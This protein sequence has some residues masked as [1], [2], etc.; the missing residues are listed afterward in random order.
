MAL[1]K[2]TLW[3]IP[4]YKNYTRFSNLID[5]IS[6]HHC[7][8]LM[9]IGVCGGYHARQMIL[10]ALEVPGQVKYYG[11]DLFEDLTEEI[12]DTEASPWPKTKAQ[13]EH[14]LKGIGVDVQLFKGFT[15]DTLP[16]FLKLNIRPD[17]IFI[18]GGHSYETVENDW[19]YVKQM[20]SDETI[21]LFDD[22]M[23]AKD[24]LGW[25]CHKIIDDLDRNLYSVEI[26]E[27]CDVYYM[28]KVGS[29]ERVLTENRIA[30]VWMNTANNTQN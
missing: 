10:T 21:V 11:F 2:S 25:G 8:V 29:D 15:R 6:K 30:K 16:E 23:A 4:V 26:L 27:P 12:H 14:R 28:K 17:L 22:Y 5:V 18:D 1:E 20:M 7:K 19:H 24:K 3:G 9:E 13:V